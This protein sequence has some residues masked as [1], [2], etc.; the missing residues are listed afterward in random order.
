MIK[1]DYKQLKGPRHIHHVVD[2]VVS[3]IRISHMRFSEM[4]CRSSNIKLKIV[5]LKKATTTTISSQNFP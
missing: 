5:S 3:A 4:L 1:M 2:A